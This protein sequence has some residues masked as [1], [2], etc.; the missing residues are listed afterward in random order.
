MERMLVKAGAY[1]FI[2]GLFLAI[3]FCGDTVTVQPAP[4]VYT[5]QVMPLREYILTV[6]RFAI[7]ISLGSVIAVWVYER[8]FRAPARGPEPSFWSGFFKA[9]FIVLG[10]I[11]TA[12]LI[13]S[14]LKRHV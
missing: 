4:N 11:G 7:K 3:L 10:L 12:V 8:F 14:A 6:L 1:G 9:F 5:S 2:T 13:F